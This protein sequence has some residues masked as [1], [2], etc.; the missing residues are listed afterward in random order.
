MLHN[1]EAVETGQHYIQHDD[2]ELPHSEQFASLI[3]P[4]RDLDLVSIFK[5]ALAQHAGNPLVIF[6]NADIHK[7]NRNQSM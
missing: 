6:D 2:V 3:A 5:Q 1:A 7:L 4:M